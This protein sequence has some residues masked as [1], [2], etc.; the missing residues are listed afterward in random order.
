MIESQDKM[1]ALLKELFVKSLKGFLKV[2]FSICIFANL[3]SALPLED[4][5]AYP[6]FSWDTVPLYAHIGKKLSF[7]DEEIEYLAKF[8]IITLEKRTGALTYGSTEKGIPAEAKRIKKINPDAKVL[9][10]WN[11]FL[12]YEL[13]EAQKMFEQHDEWALKKPDGN[14]LFVRQIVKT[15]DFRVPQMRDWWTNVCKNAVDTGVID[16][17][18]IDANLKVYMYDNIRT[19]LGDKAHDD[20]IAAYKRLLV[21]TRCKIGPDKIMLA[22]IIRAAFPDSGLSDLEYHSGSYIEGFARPWPP[23]SISYEKYLEKGIAAVQSAARNGYIITMTLGP[24]VEYVNQD[25]IEFNK[26][27]R[28]K[29]E[30]FLASR[31][32][33]ALATF[34]ICAEK[35]SYFHYASG[36][37]AEDAIWMNWYPEY[38]KPLGEPL[39]AAKKNG[40][41]YTR[42]FKNADVRLDIKNKKAKIKWRQ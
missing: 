6:K 19:I 33:Y 36:L 28:E 8:P 20:L 18:F 10:Y 24:E 27:S 30:E 14:N 34:L 16:G 26:L 3:V 17:I 13:Y 2:S 25:D 4:P 22:N 32:E 42:K 31:L 41:V 39:G 37:R 1:Y 15:Y 38:D 9:F 35:Y 21:E 7:T 23:K 40:F 12:D 29:Q 11:V 5:N